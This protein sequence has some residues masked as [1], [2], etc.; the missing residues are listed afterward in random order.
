MSF[1]LSDAEKRMGGAIS[2]LTQEFQG[3]RT[4]RA[5]TTMLESVQADAYGSRMPISQLATISVPEPRLLSVQVWDQGLVE[6]VEK[7]I[8]ESDL[9]LNP[10]REGAVIRIAV[11]DLSADRRAELAKVARKYAEAARVAIRNIRR[12]AMEQLR[13]LE[14]EGG[15]GEDERHANENK[16]QKLTDDNIAKVDALLASK[17]KDITTL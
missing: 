14:K 1:D 9:G 4:G 12:D 2:V 7:A 15:F 6:V 3:L 11:P 16:V 17:E 5:S 13:K 10:M 8:R